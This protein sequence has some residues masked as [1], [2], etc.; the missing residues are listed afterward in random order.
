M[1]RYIDAN[2]IDYVVTMVGKDENA[3]YRAVAFESDI[4]ELPTANV[5]KVIRCKNCAF[6]EVDTEGSGSVRCLNQNTPWHR[7][8]DEFVMS[9]DDY[10]KYGEER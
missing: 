2:K 6:G 10:C 1:P 8:S 4:N 3:G 5:V 7:Y 9:P